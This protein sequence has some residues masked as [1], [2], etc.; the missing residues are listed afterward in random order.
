M[1]FELESRIIESLW[2][3]E[4]FPQPNFKKVSVQK[5]T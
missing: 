1:E 2:N 5:D 4:G 3:F